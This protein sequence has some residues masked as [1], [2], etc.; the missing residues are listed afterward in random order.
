VHEPAERR[1]RPVALGEAGRE[2]LLT[3]QAALCE[4]MA[5]ADRLGVPRQMV[6]DVLGKSS[7]ASF[8]LERKLAAL[9][10][11]DTAP[12]S[13]SISRTRTWDWPGP[14]QR[15]RSARIS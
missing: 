1:R 11:H 8:I 5:L 3:N 15:S 10:K 14:R 13:S 9:V 7:G 2:G 4:A 12:G 6:G